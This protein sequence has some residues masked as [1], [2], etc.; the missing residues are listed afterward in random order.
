MLP[1]IENLIPAKFDRYFEPFLGGGAVFFYLSSRKNFR[2]DAFLSDINQELL[3]T[4]NAVR[5]SVE[6]L[7][8]VLNYHQEQYR[9]SPKLYYYRLRDNTQPK[10]DVDRAARFIALNKTC[11]NGL[12]RVNKKNL[13][14]A[15]MGRYKNPTICDAENLRNVSILLRELKPRLLALDYKKVLIENAKEGDFIYLDPPY[16]PISPTANFTT[17]TSNG[18]EKADQI[19]LADLFKKLDNRKCNILLS[20]SDI[21]FIRELYGSYS[22]CIKTVDAN[23]AINSKASKRSG[24]RELLICNYN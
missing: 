17:Y 9:F 15:P 5:Y 2:F 19:Q 16:S 3:I 20:N 18:F 13:F 8:S 4:Y 1:K 11:F 6:E 21:P 23:R 12:Y 10:N 24:Y 22:G 14:N 7:I